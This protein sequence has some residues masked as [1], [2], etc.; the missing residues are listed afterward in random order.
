MYHWEFFNLEIDMLANFKI[1]FQNLLSVDDVR[2]TGEDG[3][4]IIQDST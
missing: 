2:L 3:H 1:F 4:K